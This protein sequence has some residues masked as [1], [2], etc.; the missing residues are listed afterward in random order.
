TQAQ[1]IPATPIAPAQG[2]GREVFAGTWLYNADDSVNAATGR[3]ELGSSSRRPGPASGGP[4][5]AGSQS[6]AA[7]GVAGGPP[8]SGLGTGGVGPGVGASGV[9]AGSDEGMPGFGG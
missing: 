6:G 7:G 1:T 2:P 9:G 5:P 3:P 8:G 4:P